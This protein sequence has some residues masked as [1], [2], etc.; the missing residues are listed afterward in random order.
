M[1]DLKTYNPR[2]IVLA[3]ADYDRVYLWCSNGQFS[4]EERATV[5]KC[6]DSRAIAMDDLCSRLRRTTFEAAHVGET[7][8]EGEAW[9]AKKF[10]ELEEGKTVAELMDVLLATWD[11]EDSEDVFGDKDLWKPV[12]E[13]VKNG[14]A[15]QMPPSQEKVEETQAKVAGAIG[16][17]FKSK[18]PAAAIPNFT[19]MFTTCEEALEKAKDNFPHRDELRNN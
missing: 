17:M 7:L 15:F 16:A 10:L 18:Q 4:H 19:E 9:V 6:E 2:I 12:M 3:K 14:V 11:N 1:G 13:D 8:Y 5:G